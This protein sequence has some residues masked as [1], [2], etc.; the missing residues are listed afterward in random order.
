MAKEGF[1]DHIARRA[2]ILA[3]RL[4]LEACHAGTDEAEMN[5]HIFSATKKNTKAPKERTVQDILKLCNDPASIVACLRLITSRLSK[6]TDAV[7]IIK[8]ISVW[9]RCLSSGD[10]QFVQLCSDYVNLKIVSQDA[11]DNCALVFANTG[12]EYVQA[13]LQAFAAC[14]HEYE[15]E[16]GKT[17]LVS[18][19]PQVMLHQMAALMTQLEVIPKISDSEISGIGAEACKYLLGQFCGDCFPIL[20]A[21]TQGLEQLFQSAGTLPEKESEQYLMVLVRLGKF[22]TRM[23]QLL[24][25][26]RAMINTEMLLDP[27]VVPKLDKLLAETSERVKGVWA[28]DA[29]KAKFQVGSPKAG[30]S[31]A[32]APVA[33]SA[34]KPASQ[35]S[36][37]WANFG[38]AP[39]AANAAGDDWAAFPAAPAPAAAAPAPAPRP[40]AAANLLDD[41]FTS[42]PAA[43][44]AAAAQQWGAPT[45]VSASIP[46]KPAGTANLLDD[47]FTA[48]AAQAAPAA[49]VSFC[50]I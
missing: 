15:K 18:L 33:A 34:A 5:R 47:F 31:P 35:T 12:C 10:S 45:P 1:F 43:G 49:Q 2:S 14:K 29:V 21:I 25:Q 24:D 22:V 44:P 39:A 41:L 17:K 36:D 4:E 9:L 6:S 32:S 23:Q 3:E 27:K 50:T 42:A 11:S 26:D 30:G 38:A 7:S 8:T 46:T 20:R 28:P 48:P 19:E 16:S 13:R 37:D 40:A